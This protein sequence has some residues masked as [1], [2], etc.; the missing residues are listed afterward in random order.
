MNNEFQN[1]TDKE[2][3]EIKRNEVNTNIATSEYQRVSRELEIRD[4]EKFINIPWYRNWWM[5]YIIYPL[6]GVL[7]GSVITILL[8]K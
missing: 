3:I 6:L 7:I 4:R 8:K 1:K 5:I 2:L